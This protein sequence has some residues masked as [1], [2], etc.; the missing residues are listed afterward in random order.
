MSLMSK[1]HFQPWMMIELPPF[2]SKGNVFFF[3]VQNVGDLGSPHLPI[4]YFISPPPYFAYL[5]T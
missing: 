1:R 3:H 5:F 2:L 4:L